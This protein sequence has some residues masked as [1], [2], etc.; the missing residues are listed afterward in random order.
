MDMALSGTEAWVALDLLPGVGR[1]T[2]SKLV[3]EF[4][5]AEAVWENID[6]LKE[7]CEWLRPSALEALRNG[8]DQRRLD[9]HRE[10]LERPDAWIVTIEDDE[11]PRL[12]REI[13]DLPLLLY[14]TG[15]LYCLHGPC[16]GI[17]GSRAATGY[18]KDASRHI[19]AGLVAN[20]FAVVSGLALGIDSE[21]HRGA[22][23]HG[24][25]TIAVKGCGLDYGYPRQNLSLA[26]SIA[27]NGAVISEFP[28]GMPPEPGNFPVRNRII[29]GLCLAV[30][31]VE[32]TMKS[33]SLVTAALALEQGREVGAVP[34][35]IFSNRSDGT[36]WLIKNGARLVTSAE[37]ILGE[38]GSQGLESS[39]MNPAE[40]ADQDLELSPEEEKVLEILGPYP[41]HLNE[42]AQAAGLEAHTASGLLLKMELKDLI[43]SLPGQNYKRR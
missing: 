41:Q 37:D 6:S 21:A 33:G 29:S 9:M 4:G 2:I 24:G 15:E 16:I 25:K 23:E 36:H 27:E 34:G 8:P 19:A 13:E 32:G 18:G 30:V 40:K 1:K 10:F 42:I 35:S 17:V 20:G 22:I 14:G 26:R 38:I 5:S 31:V 7:R 3:N 11:Y 12:L 39:N 28:L 43:Q